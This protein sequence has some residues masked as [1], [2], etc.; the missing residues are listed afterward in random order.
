MRRTMTTC[1][2]LL[3]GLAMAIPP[4]LAAAAHAPVRALK[5]TVLSTMLADGEE[6]GEW[7]FAALVEA[8][9]RKI[10]FDTGAKTDVVQK[11]LGT[12]GLSLAD[13]PDVVLSHWHWD[14]IGGFM[15][16]IGQQEVWENIQRGNAIAR[17]WGA[18][19]VAAAIAFAAY[20]F[21]PLGGPIPTGIVVLGLYGIVYFA[22]AAA[23][24]MEEGRAVLRRARRLLRM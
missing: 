11:N 13:V 4:A 8:D 12:L 23:L 19:I 21:V 3:I 1:K 5:V 22:V 16:L 2:A 6:L 24:G 14:H 15:T 17:A 20:V 9:G 10:L 7:G 18:A